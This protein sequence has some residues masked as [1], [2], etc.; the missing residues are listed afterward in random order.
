MNATKATPAT[1]IPEPAFEIGLLEKVMKKLAAWDEWAMGEE[2]EEDGMEE[3]VEPEA[4]TRAPTKSQAY[5]FCTSND[6]AS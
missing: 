5:V 2:V 3:E 1:V 4:D 6:K